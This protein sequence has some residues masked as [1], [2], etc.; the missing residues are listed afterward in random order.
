[1]DGITLLDRLKNLRDEPDFR[2]RRTLSRLLVQAM[3]EFRQDLLQVLRREQDKG[4]KIEALGI[5]AASQDQSFSTAVQEVLLSDEPVEVLQTAATV[6]G[7]LQSKDS[8]QTLV[9]LLNHENPNVQLGAIYGLVALGNK[10]AVSHLLSSLD[11]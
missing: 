1:M 11:D 10:H 3:G 8:F 2:K 4:I 6:L 7:K 9:H 5:I